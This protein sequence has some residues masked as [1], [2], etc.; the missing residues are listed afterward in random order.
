VES[1][2]VEAEVAG[3]TLTIDSEIL[4]GVEGEIF[5]LTSNSDIVQGSAGDDTIYGLGANTFDSSD[6]LDGKGGTDTLVAL[7][8]QD[9]NGNDVTVSAVSTDIEV[10]KI[11]VAD[12]SSGNN[13]NA[14]V[15]LA[16]TT[17]LQE[18]W[19]DIMVSQIVIP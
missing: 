13:A 19:F 16:N 10:F 1:Y 18:I 3:T 8:T 15:N 6:I 11:K 17:G 14:T 5:S 2:T 4:D 12:D 7:M 9:A